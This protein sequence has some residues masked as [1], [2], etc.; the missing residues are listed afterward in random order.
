MDG[1]DNVNRRYFVHYVSRVAAPGAKVLDFGCGAGRM[2]EMLREAGFDAYGVD[3]RWPGADYG[4]LEDTELG[5][6]GLLRYYEPA[7]PL[8]FGDDTFDVVVSD[9]VFEHVEPLQATI[10]ELERVTRPGG[11]SYH[12]F[13]F[14]TV[15]REGHIGIP[16]AHRLPP[17]R[18]RLAYTVALRRL[19]LGT[20][21][22]DRTARRWATDSLAWI[23]RWTVYRQAEEIQAAFG[24]G[25]RLRHR[26][27]DYC[28][29]RAAGRPLLRAVLGHP[30]ATRPAS[31]LFRRLA[32]EA[33][34]V[35]RP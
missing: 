26:E 10:D 14:R 21:K 11:I 35:R 18:V 28:R 32:F 15:W 12:H 4:D 33:I 8:P 5:R 25:D 22:D 17:G 3:I 19:G 6:A 24:G 7:G 20:W 13:P 34:E 30:I 9:Q 27:I 16:L 23:D 29:F 31:A 1:E 2:V